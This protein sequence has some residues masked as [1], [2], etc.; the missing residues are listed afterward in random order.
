MLELLLERNPRVQAACARYEL[1]FSI[2]EGDLL[3]DG[4]RERRLGADLQFV[5]DLIESKKVNS[6]DQVMYITYIYIDYFII[7]FDCCQCF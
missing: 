5:E 2:T 4:T 3:P 1:D 7:I 6:G